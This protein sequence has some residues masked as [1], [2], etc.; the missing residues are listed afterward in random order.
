MQSC[1]LSGHAG[2]AGRFGGLRPQQAKPVFAQR[3][4]RL[5]PVVA[6]AS[7][8]QVRPAGQ[9]VVSC[10]WRGE[11]DARERPCKRRQSLQWTTSRRA[12]ASSC[13]RSSTWTA[14]RVSWRRR[15]RGLRTMRSPQAALAKRLGC[16]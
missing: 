15:Q 14:G 1:F 7:P 12:A 2:A 10:T 3:A 9:I 8:G 16:S 13:G 4:A 6:A 5:R 11:A